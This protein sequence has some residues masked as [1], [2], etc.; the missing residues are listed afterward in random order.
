MSPYRYSSLFVAC[1]FAFI[2]ATPHAQ[3]VNGQ[4]HGTTTVADNQ[5]IRRLF[6]PQ[7]LKDIFGEGAGSFDFARLQDEAE[8]GT[9]Y[10]DI[11]VNDQF[12]IHQRVELFRKPNGEIG[13]LIPAQVL[14]V[15]NLRFKDLPALSEKMPM[16]IGKRLAGFDHRLGSYFRYSQRLRTHY[17][18]PELVRVLRP[19]Q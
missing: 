6:S 8:I 16:D 19:A 18:S 5:T 9:R 2:A 13:I 12:L 1:A 11:Y 14:F 15:Q 7:A 10:F 17:Y 4:A 3:N